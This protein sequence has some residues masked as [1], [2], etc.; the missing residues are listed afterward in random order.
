MTVFACPWD[1]DMSL[2][3]CLLGGTMMLH[4][5]QCAGLACWGP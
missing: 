5:S 2:L 4:L 3:S 1:V